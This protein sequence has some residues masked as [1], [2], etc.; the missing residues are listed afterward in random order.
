MTDANWAHH[1]RRKARL[2]ELFHSYEGDHGGSIAFEDL[3]SALS[4]CDIHIKKE[5]LTKIVETYH[6]ED[7]EGIEFDTFCEIFDRAELEE[8]FDHV[9]VEHTKHLDS[10]EVGQVFNEFGLELGKAQIENIMNHLELD[11]EGCVTKKEFFKAVEEN[12]ELDLESLGLESIPFAGIDVGNQ[13]APA[14]PLLPEQ[15]L[16]NF[17][18]AGSISGMVSKT[19]TAPLERIKI[20]A[21]T[22]HTNY[23]SIGIVKNIIK[24]EGISGLFRGNIVGIMKVGPTAALV[25]VTYNILV[26][27]LPK[28][29]EYDKYE[30]YW[31]FISGGLAGAFANTCTYPLD[32]IRA[33]MA[34]QNQNNMRTVVKLLFHEGPQACFRGLGPTLI[35]VVPFIAIQQSSYDTIKK[36]MLNYYLP[37]VT[38]NF[39]CGISAGILAQSITF[40][41]DVI[42]RQM[43][44][45][46][47]NSKFSTRQAINQIFVNEGYRGLFRGLLPATVKVVPAVAISMVVRDAILFHLNKK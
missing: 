7:E 6:H 14:M 10:Q 8:I 4:T 15:P 44:T 29:K 2:E 9:D 16:E 42:R 30:P 38:L 33:R 3:H 12:P 41:F 20:L 24:Q 27:F 22:C 46:D 35:A 1:A 28:D 23:S 32:I 47:I 19:L 13:I 25:S 34:V 36:Y 21:Q 39:G 31:R 18:L 45:N 26:H 43:Q 11:N 40:P 17:L 5:K 37:S